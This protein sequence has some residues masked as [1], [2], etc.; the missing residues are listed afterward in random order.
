VRATETKDY[1]KILGVDRRASDEDIRKA[2]RRLAR[3]YHPDVNPGDKNS[4][5]RFKDIQ[6]AYGVLKDKKKR[7][8]YDQFGFYSESGPPPG[9]GGWGGRPGGF[10]FTGFDFSDFAGAGAGGRAGDRSAWG[11]FGDLF[12]QF[13]RADGRTQQRTDVKPGEDLEYAV[14]I[15]FWDAIRGMN[16]PLRINRFVPCGQCHSAGNISGGPQVCTECQGSG[17]VTQN[18]G[19]MQFT[20]TCPRCQGKGRLRNVCSAC[21]GEGRVSTTETVHVRIPAGVQSGSRLRVAGKGNA[22]L[23]GG[24]PGDLYIIA[25]VG[26]HPLFQRKGDD[27]HVRVPVTVTE[28]VLGAKIEVPTIEGKALLKIPPATDSGK[29]FRLRER[30]V[31]NRRTNRRGDQYVEVKIVVPE[32]PDESSKKLLREF[33]QLNPQDPRAA[34]WGQI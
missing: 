14:D 26:S 6:E 18:V 3:K 12:S 24:K 13:F 15:G 19:S 31:Y 2:Y 28:A 8:M 32:V 10:E 5:E 21:R 16:L 11:G 30:G 4:E 23:R 25:R 33:E 22:G 1:Y 29:V 7:Q 34:L 9:A 27:I 20:L 17:Q